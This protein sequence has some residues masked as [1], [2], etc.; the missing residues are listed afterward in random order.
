MLQLILA[1]IITILA[2]IAVIHIQRARTLLQNNTRTN[3]LY[4][5]VTLALAFAGLIVALQTPATTVSDTAIKQTKDTVS[6]V[7]P[8]T[9]VTKVYNGKDIKSYKKLNAT[10]YTVVLADGSTL[11]A[12]V[13]EGNKPDKKTQKLDGVV[14]VVSEYET[15]FTNSWGYDKT[16]INH[17]VQI[18]GVAD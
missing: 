1:S 3:N 2:I 18:Y 4:L 10:Q 8:R 15:L 7:A 17:N 12:N 9:T 11:V 14:V 5:M 6:T 16:K 13:D